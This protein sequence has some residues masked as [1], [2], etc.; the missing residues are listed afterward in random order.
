MAEKMKGCRSC[1]RELP[2]GAFY[3]H[4]SGKFGR[5]NYCIECQL[6][7]QR[8]RRNRWKADGQ[9]TRCGRERNL[10]PKLV[11]SK[12]VDTGYRYR[13]TLKELA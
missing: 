10:A 3:K 11:C 2:L 12:C 13:E 1:E 8:E 5:F 9:C 7:K 6:Q 4:P